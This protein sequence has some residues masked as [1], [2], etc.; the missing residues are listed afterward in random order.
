MRTI[1]GEP[2]VQILLWRQL[3]RLLQIAGA[4]RSLRVLVKI[5]ALCPLAVGLLRPER[6]VI[7]TTID[8]K[9]E[10]QAYACGTTYKRRCI[11][12][13]A[14]RELRQPTLLD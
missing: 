6:L 8:E 5:V 12:Q 10:R 14:G 2:L 3:Y 11:A 7:V 9:G 1:N 4:K 13:E